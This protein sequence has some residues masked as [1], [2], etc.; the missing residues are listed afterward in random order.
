M[1][2]FPFSSPKTPEF[3]WTTN[4][5]MQT[6]SSFYSLSSSFA[7][8]KTSF[9]FIINLS[10]VLMWHRQFFL[11]TLAG[12]LGLCPQPDQ[13]RAKRGDPHTGSGLTWNVFISGCPASAV[14]KEQAW[15][16]E[17]LTGAQGTVWTQSG[18]LK[19]GRGF[20][21]VDKQPLWSSSGQK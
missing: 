4:V 6:S 11:I 17:E 1:L 20:V 3:T 13:T 9:L 7:S 16:G 19:R 18:T 2:K 15:P 8:T 12:W 5:Q 21:A 14:S 10:S